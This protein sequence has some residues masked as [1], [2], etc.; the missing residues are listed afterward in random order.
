MPT[1]RKVLQVTT[2]GGLGVVELRPSD[3]FVHTRLLLCP[4]C[5]VGDLEHCLG[6]LRDHQFLFFS[7][8]ATLMVRGAQWRETVGYSEVRQRPL[9]A[10]IEITDIATV[11]E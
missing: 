2:R 6:G 7:C 11:T 3:V 5:H 10:Q 8:I 4:V 1:H 9:I